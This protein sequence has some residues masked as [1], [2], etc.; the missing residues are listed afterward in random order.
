LV[1]VSGELVSQV[2]QVVLDLA[3]GLVVGEINE[4]LGHL[5]DDGVGDGVELL[6]EGLQACFTPFRGLGS[7]GSGGG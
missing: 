5:V 7:G 1:S 4:A 6:A 3:E 2:T